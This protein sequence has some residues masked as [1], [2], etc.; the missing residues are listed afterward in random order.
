MTFTTNTI[1]KLQALNLTPETFDAVLEIFEEAKAKKPKKGDTVDRAA[2][3]TRL[4]ADWVL[5]KSWGVHAMSLG[6]TEYEVRRESEKFKNY[7]CSQVGAKGVKLDWARTHA[8]WCISML[9]RAGRPVIVAGE[10]PKSKGDFDPSQFTPETWAA[11]SNQWKRTS[12]WNPTWGA[13][14]GNPNCRMPDNLR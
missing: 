14:P 13:A 8:N 9:E 6:L 5:P 7:W 3:G 4:S 1:R 10:M 12:Q 2:R 11:I